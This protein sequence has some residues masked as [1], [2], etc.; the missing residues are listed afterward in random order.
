MELE[1]G[2]LCGKP[3][4]LAEHRSLAAEVLGELVQH[5]QSLRVEPELAAERLV[6][7]VEV[8]LEFRAYELVQCT[9]SCTEL[10]RATVEAVIA[11]CRLVAHTYTRV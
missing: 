2:V 7:S 6:V 8:R 11:Y 3:K 10:D 9:L 1:C 4:C 5:V